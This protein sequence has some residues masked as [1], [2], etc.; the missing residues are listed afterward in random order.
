MRS[1]VLASDTD[2]AGWR[3]AAR[4][5]AR[6]GIPPEAVSWSV[7]AADD[8]FGAPAASDAALA[9]EPL[10]A[11]DADAAP[12]GDAATPR[13]PPAFLDLCKR[14]LLHRDPRRFALMYRLL[15]RLQSEPRLL[16]VA[17]DADVGQALRWASAV[18]RDAHKMKA[19]VRFREVPGA[20]A[21]DG[22]AASADPAADDATA[23]TRDAATESG[24]IAWFEPEHHIVE[25]VAPFFARRFAA[26]RWAILTPLRSARWDGHALAFGPGATRA[27]APADDAMEDLW[28]DYYASIFNPA[29]LKVRTMQSQMPR[30]YWR[31]L[32]EAGLIAPLG[33]AAQER[34]EAMIRDTA[35]ARKS[36]TP[37]AA[38]D[39]PATAPLPT[40]THDGRA[41]GHDAPPPDTLAPESAVPAA[42]EAATLDALA[43]A[44][45]HCRACPL[46]QPATQAVPGAGRPGARVMLVGE[47]PG[48]REDIAGRAFIGPAGQLLDRALAQAGVARDEA[49]VTNAV[50]HF[51]YE[52]RGKRRLHKS[53]GQREIAACR[54]WL[55]RELELVGPRLVVALG[56]T[57]ARALTGRP[58]PIEA[59]RG[60][61]MDLP[62]RP[63]KLLVTV[64]P[65][66]LLRLP[67]EAQE[68]AHARFVADLALA[69]DGGG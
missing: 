44:E 52:L 28:R 54:P 1:I 48:D 68:A 47:A 33:A 69:S 4:G 55:E 50:K 3:A 24:Y 40:A 26:M 56:A 20:V 22:V 49:Y 12:P 18:R 51:G 30:K 31:N 41:L 6:D 45:R 58:T 66:Y 43:E 65:S 10:A 32:P 8:L 17:M 7:G 5:L 37:D 27:D 21:H 25:A 63:W 57:A 34:T 9:T 14:A 35:P 38:S 42:A 13:V 11:Y 59:N 2:L 29:R 64:H 60:R 19:Y 36:R 15:W 46:W 39:E 67:P 53:P 16:D 61:V 23:S 62:G